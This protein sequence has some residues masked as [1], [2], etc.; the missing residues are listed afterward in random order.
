MHT[1]NE[2]FTS[3]HSKVSPNRTPRHAPMTYLDLDPMTF[4]YEHDLC[5]T[6]ED[7]LA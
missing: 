2:S 5:V 1:K 6:P 4:I 3:K 7:V